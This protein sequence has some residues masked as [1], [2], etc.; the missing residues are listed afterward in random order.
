MSRVYP[1]A[2]SASRKDLRHPGD[3]TVEDSA[4]LHLGEVPALVYSFLSN[5]G[6]V[7]AAWVF[8]PQLLGVFP[9]GIQVAVHYQTSIALLRS[10]EHDSPCSVAEE[11]SDMATSVGELQCCGVGVRPNDQ[12]IVVQA[13][14]DA[15]ISEG[16]GI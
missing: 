14:A 1:P 3:G 5:P 2:L 7:L 4:A 11:D 6:I 10:G 8:Y 12:H 16:E 9:L 13:G 15:L